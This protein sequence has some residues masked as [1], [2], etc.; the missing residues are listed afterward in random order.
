LSLK[1]NALDAMVAYCDA[2]AAWKS[3]SGPAKEAARMARAA[4]H[5]QLLTAAELYKRQLIE[6]KSKEHPTDN[7]V[8]R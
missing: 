5:S 7:T 3:L 4:A 8:R 6:P 2:R 1:Q